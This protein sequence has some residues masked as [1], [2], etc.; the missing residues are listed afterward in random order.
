MSGHCSLVCINEHKVPM[1]KHGSLVVPSKTG[2]VQFRVISSDANGAVVEMGF[3]YSKADVPDRAYY[4]DYCDVV[5]DRFGYTLVFGK[6]IP[7][8]SRLR[9]KIE[10]SFPEDMFGRQLWGGSR[11]FHK[12]IQKIAD[13]LKLDSIAKVEDTDKVQTF[14]ANNV[15]MGAWGEESV[16]D[17]Y[18]ISPKDMHALTRSSRADVTLE[19]VVRVAMGTA[20]ML[21]FLEKCGALVPESLPDAVGVGNR[22]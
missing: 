14:R 3:D 8:T 20:L 13:K 16:M 18:Y 19:P 6:L 10:I 12:V 15:F 21:E 9:T 1:K 2:A 7:G 17:F 4:S 22:I 5:K 11:E